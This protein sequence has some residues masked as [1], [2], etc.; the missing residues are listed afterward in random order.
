MQ[1][2]QIKWKEPLRIFFLSRM[3]ILL[4]SAIS[5]FILPQFFPALRGQIALSSPYASSSPL[6]LYFNAWFRWDVKAY[7]NISSFG[8]KYTPYTAFFPLWPLLQQ[9]GGFLLGGIFPA[10]YYFAGLFLSNI[11]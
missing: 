3:V 10:S 1:N 6:S 5:I 4:T 2:R 7:V 9:W 11:F 8:Y